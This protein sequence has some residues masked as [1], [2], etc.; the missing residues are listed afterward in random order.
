MT[1]KNKVNSSIYEATKQKQQSVLNLT[2]IRIHIHMFKLDFQLT[3]QTDKIFNFYYIFP[4]ALVS[5]CAYTYGNYF[6]FDIQ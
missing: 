4:C 6:Q 2:T 5:R 3:C 1:P